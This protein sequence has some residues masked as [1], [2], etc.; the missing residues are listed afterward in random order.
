MYMREIAKTRLLTPEEET[1]LGTR[2]QQG[3]EKAAE[4]LV[5]RNLRFAIHLAKQFQ[6][7]GLAL[8]DL[9]QEANIGLWEAAHRF[10]PDK[11]KR[12]LTYAVYWMRQRIFIALYHMQKTVRTPV[13]QILANIRLTK[14]GRMFEQE[15]GRFPTPSELADITDYSEHEATMAL[16]STTWTTSMDIKRYEDGT[17]TYE[18]VIEDKGALDPE[19]DLIDRE[20]SEKLNKILNQLP[21]RESDTLRLFYGIQTQ[22]MSMERIGKLFGVCDE[23]IRQFRKKGIKRLQDD[24]GAE[25]AQIFSDAG[26][27]GV[28]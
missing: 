23:R 26:Y 27:S 25:L 5:L 6:G 28:R 19:D 3:D 22:R 18:D 9:I 24:Y 15:H 16:T 1:A 4:E 14:T 2:V 7:Y 21:P 20:T 8:V 17:L 12:F 11:G 10:D 13:N